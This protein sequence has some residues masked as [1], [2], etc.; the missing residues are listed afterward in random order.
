MA[1]CCF[2]GETQTWKLIVKKKWS[3][4]HFPQVYS[5]LLSVWPWPWSKVTKPFSLQNASRCCTFFQ[6]CFEMLKRICGEMQGCHKTFKHTWNLDQRSL[7]H[8]L[9]SLVHCKEHFHPVFFFKFFP[10]IKGYWVDRELCHVIFELQM[11]PFTL[12]KG[13]WKCTLH[14]VSVWWIFV[15]SY[16]NISSIDEAMWSKSYM[17]QTDKKEDTEKNMSP[18]LSS[19]VYW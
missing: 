11:W 2:L 19:R 13:Q 3:S 1:I 17:W 12:I 4:Q 8:N 16:F 7:G 5:T 14:T 15:S 18:T 6:R 9:C 10:R